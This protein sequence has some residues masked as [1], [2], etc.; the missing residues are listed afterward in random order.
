MAFLRFAKAAIQQPSINVGKGGWSKV[1]QAAQATAKVSENLIDRASEIFGKPFVPSDYLLTHATIVASV[2][3]FQPP[4][5]KLGSVMEG[6]FRVNRKYGNYRVKLGT[7]KYINNNLDCWDRDVLKKS[8]QTFIGG[9]NFVEHVQVEDLSKGRIID[10]VARDIGDSLYVDILIATDRKHTDLVTAIESGKMSTLSMGCF[11]PGTLVT[12]SDGTRIPIEDVAPGDMVLTHKGRAREVLNKQNRGGQWDMRTV[13]AVGLTSPI[14]STGNHPYYVLRPAEVCACGC[15]GDLPAYAPSVKKPTTRSLARKFKVGHDKRILNP[16][17]TYSMDEFKRR[18]AQMDE[19]KKPELVEVRADELRV[20]DFIAFPRVKDG[21]HTVATTEGK[22]RLLGYFLAEGSFLK[23][24]GKHTSVQFNFG[25]SEKDTFAAE[26]QDL[27]K[28]EFDLVND[29]WTF[30]REDRNTCTVTVTDPVAVAWFLTQGG[31]YSHGKGLSAEAMNW[32]TENHKHL[33]G[34]WLNGDGHRAKAHGGFLV[35]TT[36]SLDLA[37]QMHALMAKCGWFARFE[38]RIGAKSV[39]VAEAV[40]GGVAV[41]DEATGRLP[42][43][44]LTIGNT[45]SVEL[46]GYC[47]KAPTSSRYGVQNNRTFEDWVVSPITKIE[48]STYDGWVHDMEV[49]EDHT[50][51]AEGASVSNCTVDGTQCTKCGHWAADETEQCMC[52]KYEKGNTFFD[53]QGRQHRVAEL[54]GHKSLDPTAG[55]TFIE[56]SWVGTPAFT[57]AV[58]QNIIALHQ[59]D[60][61]GKAASEMLQTPPEEWTKGQ[62]RKAAALAFGGDHFMAGWGDEED[63]EEGDEAPAEDDSKGPFD[64]MESELTEHMRDRVKKKLKK[65]MDEKDLDEALGPEDSSTSPNDNVVKQSEWMDELLPPTAEKAVYGATIAFLCRSASNDADLLDKVALL[66]TEYGVN[67]PVPMYRAALRLGSIRG[68]E[69]VNQFVRACQ[70]ALGRRPTTAEANVLLRL[71]K[72]ISRRGQAPRKITYP[73][74]VAATGK[75][76]MR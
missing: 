47:A 54:C 60:A 42:A 46:Q 39:T 73:N 72:L 19:I 5:A 41:R 25:L 16:N 52:I 62:R 17:N 30:D 38:A 48:E 14:T 15:G 29:P 34:T 55:V 74:L 76:T 12:L 9:H 36:V 33:I 20:G 63:E 2:D 4:N 22:A 56:G 43:Y 50:Y 75:E 32:S 68:Y 28:Q 8:Y 69:S 21:E 57:G 61:L 59:G 53:D 3:T 27:L 6:G 67:I 31:E 44:L 66:N 58:L 18:R 13:H 11:L 70:A 71:G 10:A 45:Q 65:D 24:A 7:D 35:G 49:D 23:T 40:N 37:S 1:R 64:D 51:I 26:V